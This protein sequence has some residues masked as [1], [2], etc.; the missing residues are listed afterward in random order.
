[1]IRKAMYGM[2]LAPT[3]IGFLA[4][5]SPRALALIL[6]LSAAGTLIYALMFAMCDAA[7]RADERG[8]R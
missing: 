2:L 3:A 7:G 1:M 5:F 8:D 4:G 6:V